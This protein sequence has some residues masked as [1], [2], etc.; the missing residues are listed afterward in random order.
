[1]N[2][3][4]SKWLAAWV[5]GFCVPM[6]ALYGSM[7]RIEP[8][9][10]IPTETTQVTQ[11]VLQMLDVVQEDGTLT[12]MPLEEYITCVVLREMP[13]S[14]EPE[15]LK[16]Q[17]VVARTYALRRSGGNKHPGGGICTKSSCCQGFRTEDDY[18]AAGGKPEDV[19]KIRAAVEAT[20]GLVLTY[21]GKLIDAT[22]FS[23]SG[24]YTE[25][26]AA[27]WGTDVPY[28]QSIQSPGEEHASHFTDTV[29]FTAAEFSKALGR[30]LKGK[31]D[32]WF[33]TLIRTEGGGVESLEISGV[34]YQGTALRKLLDLR[35]TAF[36][37]SVSGQ[38]VTVTTKGYGHR[39][40]MSQYGADAMAASGSDF[41]EILAHYYQGT[42]LTEASA[43]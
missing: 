19:Q 1:M 39:V 3:P 11:P 41:R 9:E 4:L 30:T 31:P 28:L 18:L 25:D 40:G 34:T 42:L 43:D 37:I 27:V 35:S 33:G 6:A 8:M 20:Q 15:A 7:H 26:A 29:T 14:F 21:G 38:T 12:Q 23:C 22:Y 16:A 36:T 24:G 32:T 17:A 10:T 13:A 2:K 5:L